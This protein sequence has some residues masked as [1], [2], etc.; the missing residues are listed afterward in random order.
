[1]KNNQNTPPLK[2]TSFIR[3]HKIALTITS[4]V[5]LLIV[6]AYGMPVLVGDGIGKFTGV[7]RKVAEKSLQYL[8]DVSDSIQRTA[9]ELSGSHDYIEDVIEMT[10]EEAR[11]SCK[12]SLTD[13]AKGY[14]NIYIS[15]VTLFGFRSERQQQTPLATCDISQKVKSAP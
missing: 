12:L 6:L 8:Y 14:Y 1:M 9:D 4:A 13:D 3:R 2:S 7:K 11:A 10:P 5:V 15:E